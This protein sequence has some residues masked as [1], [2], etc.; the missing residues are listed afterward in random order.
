MHQ[1]LPANVLLVLDA[2][3]AEYV[4]REDYEAGIELVSSFTNVVDDPDV[5]KIHGLAALRIG[6]LYGPTDVIDALN[7]FAAHSMLIQL[8]LLLEWQRLAMEHM[9]KIL[10]TTTINGSMD[11]ASVRAIGAAGNTKC[12]QFL[13]DT[14]SRDGRKNSR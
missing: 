14:F 10:L 5:F 2:A 1:G 8:L 9:C 12:W 4:H 7:G 11:Q 6:W 3:Y 13:A